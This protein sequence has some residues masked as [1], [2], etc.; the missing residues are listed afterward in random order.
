[1]KAMWSMALAMTVGVVL[2]IVGLMAL[3]MVFL[4]RRPHRAS[5]QESQGRE[6]E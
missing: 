1:M 4:H 2:G 5:A 6:A 3:A